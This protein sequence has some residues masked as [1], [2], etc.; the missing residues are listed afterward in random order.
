M[1]GRRKWRG[2]RVDS[3]PFHFCRNWSKTLSLKNLGLLIAPLPVRP[4]NPFGFSDL[5]KILACM[6]DSKKRL[7][8]CYCIQYN[9]LAV[10]LES[11]KDVTIV[12][13]D[14]CITTGTL[15]YPSHKV[16][17]QRNFL[18]P[19]LSDFPTLLRPSHVAVDR[20]SVKD[21]TI[22]TKDIYIMTGTLTH[23]SH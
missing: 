2:R 8:I 14:I 11:V 12:T 19:T 13:K 21:V 23:P 15:T 16:S 22:V 4:P 17:K 5:H 20:E 6:S 1:Q 10:D 7:H 3:P 18:P 9:E